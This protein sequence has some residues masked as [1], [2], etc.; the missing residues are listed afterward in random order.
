MA[1][2]EEVAEEVVALT[3]LLTD[4]QNAQAPQMT[5]LQ[6]V[7]ALLMLAGWRQV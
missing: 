5:E 3:S 7:Q 1:G 4:L 2:W 6:R